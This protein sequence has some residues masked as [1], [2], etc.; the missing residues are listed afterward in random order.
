MSL[1]EYSRHRQC[2]APQLLEMT[3]AIAAV[4]RFDEIEWVSDTSRTKEVASSQ[5][6][7]PRDDLDARECGCMGKFPR[8][9]MYAVESSVRRPRSYVPR[10][11]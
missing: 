10:C 4:A 3:K 2:L 9:V 7:S 5:E 8:V 1:T 6:H 11:Y